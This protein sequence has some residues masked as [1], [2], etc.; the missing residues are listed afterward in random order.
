MA[1]SATALTA[2]VGAFPHVVRRD[3]TV[4]QIAEAMYG[5]VELE[6]V[7]VAANSLDR[8]RGS[9][10]VAGMRLELPAIG[11]HKV[12]P[13]DTWQSIADELLGAEKRGDVLAHINDSHPWLKP[14]VGR[15]IVVPYNL[16]YVATRGDT[17]QTVAYRF[18]NRRDD[19]WIIASYNNLSRARLRQGEVV[20]V[21]LTDLELTDVGRR[22]ALTA[23]ALVRSQGGGTAR[24]AQRKAAGELPR[25]ALDI[26]RGRYIEAIGRGAAILDTVGLSEPQL[27]ETHR[28]LTVAYVAMDA[29][30][31]AA[32]SCAAWRQH[33]PLAVLDP[34]D[35][36]PKVL[37]VCVG[38]A[39]GL[40]ISAPASSAD[41]GPVDAGSVSTEGAQ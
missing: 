2:D 3:E 20:L 1:L 11:Y 36:S 34:I 23:G 18:L 41:A 5:R 33:D 24:E 32:T 17:T 14:S 29:T 19:A 9:E 38:E 12:L 30:G 40:S 4:A 35:H 27:A 6:R 13:E 39:G 21:P 7:I 25:L 31:L 10:I 28:L 8:R 16:R 37:A 26:R 22:S 15:E